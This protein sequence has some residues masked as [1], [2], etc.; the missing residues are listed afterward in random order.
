M[1]FKPVMVVCLG[2]LIASPA[3][4]GPT[5]Q[6]IVS[7]GELRC[8][9]PSTPE[10][11]N[12]IDLHGP[13]AALDV[14][15][16][17]AIAV[18]VLG[19]KAKVDLHPFSSELEAEEG[20]SKAAVDVVIGVTPEAT[21]RWHWNIAFG[22]PVF[23]DGQGFLVRSDAKAKRIGDLA[24]ALVC[25]VDGTDNEKIL[26]ARTV[27]KGIALVPIVFQEE[28]EMDDG[29]AVRHCDAITAYK[30][31]LAALKITYPKQ[32]GNDTVLPEQL[33]LSPV[34]P[35]YR[36]DDAQ[37]SLIVDWTIHALVQA[38]TSGLT[39]ANVKDQ[40]ANEDPIVQRITGIDWATSR[41]LGLTAKDWA[42]QVIAVTGNYG[43]I[44]ERTVG[45]GSALRIPR[46]INAL[47]TDGGLM[48]A[49]PVQ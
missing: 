11:W 36:N 41:A 3:F 19:T 2:A 18:A 21:A 48:H 8:G 20:L 30:S 16:C 22:P 44:Y 47:W 43:E 27:A 42:L 4:G 39:M 45:M 7:A 46:G 13:L 35:A 23:Y 24:G 26:R 25:V 17:K 9:V 32:L 29:L 34:A 5:V 10:D 15:I 6:R 49:L 12:K 14:E 38:E 40:A 28:G 1:L 37:W 31:R 33:T